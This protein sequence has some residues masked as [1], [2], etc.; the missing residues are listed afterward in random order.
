MFFTICDVVFILKIAFEPKDLSNSA[1]P[2]PLPPFTKSASNLC[3]TL[4][5]YNMRCRLYIKNCLWAKRS[6]KFN[7]ARAASPLLKV[8]QTYAKPYVFTIC[9]VVFIL[10]NA[11]EPK[12]LSNSAL[13]APLPLFIKSAPKLRT[14]LCVKI[15]NWN[16]YYNLK[17][18]YFSRNHCGCLCRNPSNPPELKSILFDDH[19]HSAS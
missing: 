11:F 18:C 9:D 1:L 12:D 16:L 2:A 7:I 4:C 6:I 17:P 14:T 10:K 3:Q 8:R 5:F 19:S 15:H 13:P